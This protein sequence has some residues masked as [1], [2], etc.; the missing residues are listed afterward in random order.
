MKEKKGVERLR[1]RAVD[2]RIAPPLPQENFKEAKAEQVSLAVH[3]FTA[4]APHTC[5]VF[6]QVL[7]E[8]EA[9]EAQL[10]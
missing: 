3:V 5:H 6:S 8:R 4:F 2:L 9:V 1:G 7:I 10:F